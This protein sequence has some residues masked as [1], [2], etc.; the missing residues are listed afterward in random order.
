MKTGSDFKIMLTAT[1][2]F[3]LSS[4]LYCQ[5]TETKRYMLIRSTPKYT[6]QLDVDY[7]QSFLELSGAYNDDYQSRNVF[8]GETFGADKGYGGS[9]I[10][11]IALNER[12]SVRFI[13]SLT[14][15]RILAYTFGDKTNIADD[16]YANYNCYTGGLGIEYNF[17]PR[18]KFKM[19]FS[20]EL[21]ASMING[22]LR[23]WFYN[24]PIPTSDTNY[25]VT[26]SF[27]IGFGLSLGSEYLISEKF[28]LN[29]GARLINANLFLKQAEGT[30]ADK[31]FK[32]RDAKSPGLNFAGTKNFSFFT[33]FV[34]I[35]FYFGIKEK[36][37]KLN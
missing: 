11:K 33:I 23:I 28:G 13:Q 36:V 6:I 18:H 14:Y 12:G 32:L 4:C 34:G 16:G 25:K 21:N 22:S 19:Y 30:N 31:E 8:D 27:R 37:Y 29:L 3:A 20:G 7:N 9:L 5:K 2:M 35:N 1:L 10:S 17:T 15:N 24:P 26:N